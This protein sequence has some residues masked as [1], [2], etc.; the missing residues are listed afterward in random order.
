MFDYLLC[1]IFQ[2]YHSNCFISCEATKKNPKILQSQT[3]S[4]IHLFHTWHLQV[5]RDV[6]LLR[7]LSSYFSSTSTF[8]IFRWSAAD[9][10]WQSLVAWPTTRLDRR[11]LISKYRL[12]IF[13]SLNSNNV[14]NRILLFLSCDELSLTFCHKIAI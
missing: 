5:F 1:M 9:L 3:K 7:R 13:T 11:L 4:K 10:A 8:M 12:I 14:S 2:K 6:S